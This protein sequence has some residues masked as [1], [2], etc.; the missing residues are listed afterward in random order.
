MH[1]A[2]ICSPEQFVSEDRESYAALWW[3]ELFYLFCK[4]SLDVRFDYSNRPRGKR[5]SIAAYI[6]NLSY[7]TLHWFFSHISF[8]KIFQ[9][10][11]LDLIIACFDL[12]YL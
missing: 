10:F 11:F 12:K 9:M 3:I 4:H 1:V 5:S 6:F 7:C 2:D 8:L